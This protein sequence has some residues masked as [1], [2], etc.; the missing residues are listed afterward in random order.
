MSNFYDIGNIIRLSVAFTEIDGTTPIDPTAIQLNV[1][2]FG[3]D[4]QSFTYANAQVLRDGAGLYHYDYMP[5]QAGLY[6]YRYFGTGAAVAAGDGQFSVDD[7]ATLYPV[8]Y[9]SPS[10]CG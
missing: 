10:C 5:D 8:P 4:V 1:R 6:Y 9:P 7:S 3:G 2:L